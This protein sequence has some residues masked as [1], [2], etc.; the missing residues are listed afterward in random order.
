MQYNSS[1]QT[2]RKAKE[3]WGMAAKMTSGLSEEF[4]SFYLKKIQKVN[5]FKN[6]Y[7]FLHIFIM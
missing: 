4:Y 2:R 1:L 7:T 6:T 5:F 3:Q